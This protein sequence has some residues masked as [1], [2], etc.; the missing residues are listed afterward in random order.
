MIHRETAVHRDSAASPLR[1]EMFAG[2]PVPPTTRRGA[3]TRMKSSR[4]SSTR[5]S[6]SGAGESSNGRIV[7]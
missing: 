6:A 5:A 1:P 2:E 4:P 3:M 7:S